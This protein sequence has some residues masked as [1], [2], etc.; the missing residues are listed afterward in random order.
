VFELPS[1]ICLVLPSL[2]ERRYAKGVFYQR[3]LPVVL[4]ENQWEDWK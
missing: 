3:G 1:D 2:K 4:L